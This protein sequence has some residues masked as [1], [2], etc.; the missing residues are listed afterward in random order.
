MSMVLPLPAY[1]FGE[2]I[3]FLS[4]QDHQC[5]IPVSWEARRVAL[6]SLVAIHGSLLHGSAILK[7]MQRWSTLKLP[8]VCWSA[9]WRTAAKTRL[10]QFLP[11]LSDADFQ[12]RVDWEDVW[13]TI[14]AVATGG[15]S[16]LKILEETKLAGEDVEFALARELQFECERACK[17]GKAPNSQWISAWCQ[18]GAHFGGERKWLTKLEFPECMPL[19]D[20]AKKTANLSALVGIVELLVSSGSLATGE[21]VAHAWRRAEESSP[22]HTCWKS[23]WCDAATAVA[24]YSIDECRRNERDDRGNARYIAEELEKVLSVG[25]H[26]SVLYDAHCIVARQHMRD[27]DYRW[28]LKRSSRG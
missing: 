21:E 8:F 25:L 6:P 15:A 23:L 3:V 19:D 2:C 5:V 10:R 26:G 18:L 1:V 14:A 4:L 28:E 22:E 9:P 7:A 17:T 20:V 16:E 11:L 13:A 27:E 12:E 24:I